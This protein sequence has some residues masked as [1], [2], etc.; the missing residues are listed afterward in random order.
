M[1]GHAY[2]SRMAAPTTMTTT[3]E[4]RANKEDVVVEATAPYCGP[5]LNHQLVYTKHP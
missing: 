3:E 4:V 2:Q 1:K 5:A